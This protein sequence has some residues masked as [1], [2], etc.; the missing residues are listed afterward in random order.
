MAL[1]I[2]YP[3]LPLYVW[4][5]LT[6][7]VSLTGVS[8]MLCNGST[9]TLTRQ[10]VSLLQITL[11]NN[12]IKKINPSLLHFPVFPVGSHSIIIPH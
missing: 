7:I 1:V 9:T 12:T 6:W 11:S 5:V 10:F 3:L 8:I 2:K 4:D